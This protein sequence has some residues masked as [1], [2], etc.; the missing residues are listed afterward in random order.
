MEN[1]T[2][3]LAGPQLMPFER[4]GCQVY[5]VMVVKLFLCVGREIEGIKRDFIEGVIESPIKFIWLM[6]DGGGYVYS[7]YL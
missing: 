4:R 1:T 7:L 3:E 2:T 6:D 5:F